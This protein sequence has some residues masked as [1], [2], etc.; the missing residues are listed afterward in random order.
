MTHPL[1]KIGFHA[2]GKPRGW[3][4]SL[5]FDAQLAPRPLFKRWVCPPAGDIHPAFRAWRSLALQNPA[6][7]SSNDWP[8]R[9]QRIVDQKSLGSASSLRIVCTRATA[10]V[11]HALQ[12][13]AHAW[14]FAVHI[15]HE[16][17]DAFP[18]DMYLVICPQM[19]SHLP[20]REKRIVFQME[21]SVHPRWFTP[22]YLNILYNSVAVFDYSAQNIQF[23]IQQGLPA[24][25]LFHV[26]LSPVPNHPGAEFSSALA[27][28]DSAHACD[29]L[30]YGDLKN[31]RRQAFLK[32]LGEHFEVRAERSLYGQD[33]WRAMAHAK[34]V[35]NIHY[36]ENA[37]LEST[38]IC[39]CLSLG[40]RVISEAATDQG[41]HADWEDLVVF[42]PINDAQAMVQAI[43]QCLQ[44][45]P[46]AAPSLTDR[47]FQLGPAFENAF[48][49]LNLPVH[50]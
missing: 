35:V 21:Q 10:F 29:V 14:G 4:T 24:D 37:L 27:D 6:P 36:Y 19:F 33:L 47:A 1:K 16:M 17:P 18:E 9:R 31:K 5:V 44:Q 23:L 30:F 12:T 50:R 45:T 32:V 11:A 15:D 39:E 7:S 8:L 28:S 40:A 41:Q 26:P 3:L 42:T 38:R 22:E 2:N 34:V 49:T 25:M 13:H 20:P 48:R 46:V 43:H